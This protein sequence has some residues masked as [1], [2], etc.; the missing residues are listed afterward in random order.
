VSLATAH[1]LSG[2]RLLVDKN[3]YD[4]RRPRRWEMVVFRCPNPRPSEFG[5]P[6]VKR[7]VGMPGE[8][9][10]IAD[11]DVYANGVLLRKDLAEVRETLVPVFDMAF[12]PRPG[13]WNER[14]QVEAGSTAV[15]NDAL[16]LD[17]SDSP[18]SAA[19][20][21]YRHWNLDTRAA[22]PVRVWNAYNGYPVRRDREPAA[23]DFFLSCEVEVTAPAGRRVVR[24]P[25]VGRGRRRSRPRSGSAAAGPGSRSYCTTAA[26]C[27]AAPAGWLS[28]RGAGTGWSSRSSTAG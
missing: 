12:A 23:H 3:V 26:A 15:E 24:V 7:L 13:G 27:W 9:I 19:A 28:N 18:Q 20:V 21:K 2:D 10:T 22:E 16:V 8:T 14:W 17:A 5:K 25:P 6:Y 4:L 11:G 1:E